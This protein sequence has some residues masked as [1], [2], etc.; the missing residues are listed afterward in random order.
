MYSDYFVFSTVGAFASKQSP[1]LQLRFSFASY[2]FSAVAILVIIY[3]LVLD[4]Y[5]IETTAKS[6][7]YLQ[8]LLTVL[9]GRKYY[10]TLFA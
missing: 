2:I 10:L 6:T 9:T 3:L 5:K 1:D 8:P 7:K 4:A